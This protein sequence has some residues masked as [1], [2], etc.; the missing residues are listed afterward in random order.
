MSDEHG[1]VKDVQLNGKS[2]DRNY[3]MDEELMQGGTLKFVFGAERG[4]E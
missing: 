3:V 4:A 1:F 2:L